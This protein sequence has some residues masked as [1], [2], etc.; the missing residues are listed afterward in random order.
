MKSLRRSL[1]EII[2]EA[3]TPAGKAFDLGLLFAIILSVTAVMLESVES[4]SARYGDA[5]RYIEWMFTILFTLEYIVRLSTTKNPISYIFS[6]YGIIDLLSIIPT[7]LGLIV[8]GSHSLVVI[9]TIRLLRVFRILKLAKF[10]GQGRYLMAAMKASRPKII[11]FFVAMLTMVVILGT[12]MY[13]IEG[14]ESGFNSIP[15]SIYWA[16]V[17]LTTVGYGD[18]A[19]QTAIGQ[20]FASFVMIMGYAVIAVPTGIVTVEL[21]KAA[22]V[23]TNTHM[24]SNCGFDQHDDDAKFC[25]KCGDSLNS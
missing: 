18:L 21:S 9:R 25:K 24:C 23:S 15:E 14:E 1:Y 3:D 5:L 22:R 20:A 7:Y 4:I 13:L 12:L 16:I 6:F 17:T 8:T 2:F 19:P 11:V 10:V